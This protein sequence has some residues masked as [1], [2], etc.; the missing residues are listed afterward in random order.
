M[1]SLELECRYGID[2]SQVRHVVRSA[3]LD[4]F[5]QETSDANRANPAN[6]S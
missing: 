5:D 1:T 2:P 3:L 6:P 4:V